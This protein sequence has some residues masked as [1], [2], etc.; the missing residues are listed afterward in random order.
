MSGLSS[1]VVVWYGTLAWNSLLM[2]VTYFELMV[3]EVRGTFMNTCT[4]AKRQLWSLESIIYSGS[5]VGVMRS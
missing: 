2:I 5:T 1:R 4:M 3:Q